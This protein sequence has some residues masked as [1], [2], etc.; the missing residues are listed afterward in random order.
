MPSS[1]K[2]FKLYKNLLDIANTEFSAVVESGVILLSQSG[3]P[4]KLRLVL[5]DGS[6]MD[7]HYSVTGRYSYHWDRRLLD[8]KIYRH[9]NAPHHT[10]KGISGF[11]KHFH[12]GSDVIVVP[13][14]IS[15]DPEI[16]IREILR[17]AVKYLTDD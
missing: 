3:E 12:D 1:T 16:A 11:P 14:T 15:D 17:F 6:F 9:D 8:G 2:I 5:Y 13:S 7:V 4:W 10:G